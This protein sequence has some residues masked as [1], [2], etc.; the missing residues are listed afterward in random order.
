VRCCENCRHWDSDE[1]E[2]VKEGYG[3][4][5]WGLCQRA[6]DD[7]IHDRQASLMRVE[8]GDPCME[9]RLRTYKGFGCYE[10]APSNTRRACGE[11][12][13]CPTQLHEWVA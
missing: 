12:P 10:Y 7:S 11:C 1:K 5:E 13:A 4:A 9:T 2:R 6:V 8:Q 3:W